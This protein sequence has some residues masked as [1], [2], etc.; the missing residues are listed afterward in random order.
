MHFQ[1]VDFI[2]D[3]S[4]DCASLKEVPRSFQKKRVNPDFGGRGTETQPRKVTG[5]NKKKE[6]KSNARYKMVI[7]SDI[8]K[9]TGKIRKNRTTGETLWKRWLPKKVRGRV[10]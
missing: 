5:S 1:R 8:A 9:T 7:V 10:F 4:P 2:Q 3:E 6:G